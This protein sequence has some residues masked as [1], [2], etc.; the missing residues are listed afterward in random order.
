[1][2]QSRDCVK[3]VLVLYKNQTRMKSEIPNSSKPQIRVTKV[4]F[5]FDVIHERFRES[6]LFV[7]LL[8]TSNENNNS[9]PRKRSIKFKFY[10]FEKCHRDQE[11]FNCTNRYEFISLGLIDFSISTY[12]KES[13]VDVKLV[14]LCFGHL[15]KI[16]LKRY[17][18]AFCV[19]FSSIEKS[20]E[21]ETGQN[22]RGKIL[23]PLI[24]HDFLKKNQI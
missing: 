13:H 23:T 16:F 4:S 9:R 20:R 18:N 7:P 10:N 17:V 8:K 24:S 6:D 3:S 21:N 14:L 11:W 15:R 22:F 19:Q 2:H 1:M 5:D 12:H